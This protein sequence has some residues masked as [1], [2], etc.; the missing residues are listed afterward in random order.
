MMPVRIVEE[1][2]KNQFHQ[3]GFQYTPAVNAIQNIARKTGR[4]VQSAVLMITA[5]M[6]KFMPINEEEL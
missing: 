5:T 2:R 1:K 3:T 4:R 6:I